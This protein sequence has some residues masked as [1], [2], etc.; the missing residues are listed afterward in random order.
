M[1]V[2]LPQLC[3]KASKVKFL[4]SK[5]FL[6]AKFRKPRRLIYRQNHPPRVQSPQLHRLQ[7]RTLDRNPAAKI[8]IR[9]PRRNRMISLRRI[10]PIHRKK[11]RHPNPQILRRPRQRILFLIRLRT[12]PLNRQKIPPLIQL[13]THPPNRQKILRLNQKTV[14]LLTQTRSSRKK[15]PPKILLFWILPG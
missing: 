7:K 9:H 2:S 8:R 15:N 11:I 13:R 6:R 14:K 10:I 12:H 4:F 5:S 3:R 1:P